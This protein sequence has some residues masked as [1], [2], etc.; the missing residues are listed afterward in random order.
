VGFF[1]FFWVGFL[2][3]TLVSGLAYHFDA[4][5]DFLLMWLR[6]LMQIQVTKMMRI[7]AD[8]DPQNCLPSQH[9]LNFF[10]LQLVSRA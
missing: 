3:P 1:G 9:K 6:I 4:D 5:P 2:M 7:H 8:P 10:F